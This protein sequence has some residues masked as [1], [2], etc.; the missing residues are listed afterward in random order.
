MIRIAGFAVA[1]VILLCG[2]VLATDSPTAAPSIPPSRG[3][4]DVVNKPFPADTLTQWAKAETS[5]PAGPSVTLYRW[6]T[7]TCPFCAASLPAIETLRQKYEPQG[8]RVVAVYHPKPPRAI[9]DDAVRAAAT[10]IDYH[11]AI[12]VDADWSVLKR[13]W[14]STGQREATSVSFLVDRKGI[15]RFVHPGPDFFA[16]SKAT[17]ARQDKDYREMEKAIEAL[18]LE[19]TPAATKPAG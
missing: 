9:S 12:A 5:P 6:W 18:L 8:L 1:M 2:E 4:S 19:N 17:E 13:V 16:S 15:I 10:K 14:L 3:G 11:G 7:D